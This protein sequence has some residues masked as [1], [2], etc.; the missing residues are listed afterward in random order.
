MNADGETQSPTPAG[1]Q[2]RPESLA[3][4]LPRLIWQI[5]WAVLF[6]PS[7]RVLHGWR[8]LLLR[9][10]GARMGKGARVYP[11]CRIWAPWNLQMGAGSII[12]PRVDCYCVAAIR[13]GE[14][15]IVSQY[16]YLCTAS[17]DYTLKSMPTTAGPITIGDDAWVCADVFVAPGVTVGQGAVVGARSSVF[18]DVEPWAVA[19]GNPAKVIKKRI[20]RDG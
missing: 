12:G 10:F 11:T 18:A 13:L 3:S 4:R 5:V 15:A 19:A 16:S 7:P 1:E 2:L 20:L 6:R 8:R 9:A 14:R 17:H